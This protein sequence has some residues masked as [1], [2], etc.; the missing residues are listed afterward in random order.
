MIF[1]NIGLDLSPILYKMD[2]P[3]PVMSP[4]LYPKFT[5]TIL[6][7]STVFALITAFFAAVYPALKASRLAPVEA[8]KSDLK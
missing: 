1:Q 6:F 2:L 4:V 7:F 5:L 3:L 8:L